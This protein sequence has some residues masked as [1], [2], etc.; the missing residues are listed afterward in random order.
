[1]GGSNDRPL[2]SEHWL[3]S[4]KYGDKYGDKYGE[5]YGDNVILGLFG[6]GLRGAGGKHR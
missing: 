5:K 3:A 1:M 2:W 4:G 6:C